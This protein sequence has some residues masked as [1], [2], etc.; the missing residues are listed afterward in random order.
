VPGR[1]FDDPKHPYTQMLLEAA[2]KMDA[3]GR[4]I[5]PPEGEIPD[6]I[7]PPPGCAFHPRCPLAQDICKRDRPRLRQ[8]GGT[9]VAC[10]FAE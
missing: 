2:P 4:E 3:F 10:H 6:P 8:I 9:R 1:L 5:Q 7:N